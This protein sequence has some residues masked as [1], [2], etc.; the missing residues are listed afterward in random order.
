MI[1]TL[2]ECGL[3]VIGMC[4]GPYHNLA[5]TSDNSLWSWGDNDDGQSG[6]DIDTISK[7]PRRIIFFEGHEFHQIVCGEI[8]CQ[9]I[10]GNQYFIH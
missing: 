6:I 1:S 5:L 9:V 8:N 7:I 10:T 4:C 2:N 3:K